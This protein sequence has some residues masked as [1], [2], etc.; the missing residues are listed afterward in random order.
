MSAAYIQVLLTLDI[1][2]VANAMNPDQ[3]I[4]FSVHIVCIIDYLRKFES[5]YMKKKS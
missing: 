2:R 3:T 1:I 5:K 4:S